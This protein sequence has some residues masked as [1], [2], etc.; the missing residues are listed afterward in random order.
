[1]MEQEAQGWAYTDKL[2]CV[3]CVDDQALEDAIGAEESAD[4]TCS[5]CEQS[6]AA[7]LDVLMGV[8]VNGL[9]NEYNG[10]D[11]EFVPYETR[12]GGYQFFAGPGRDSWD[13]VGEFEDILTGE[14]L[15]D[16]V[17]NSI[18][19]TM[20][21]ERDYVWR[22]RD[23]VLRDAWSTFSETVKY[24]T[25]YVIW[26]VDEVDEQ[27]MLGHGELP[28]GRILHEVG[29]LLTQLELVRLIPS[30]S[31]IWRAQ[32]H[33]GDTL[34]PSPTAGRL[35]TGKREHAKQPNRMSPSG[36]PMFYGAIDPDT[37]VAEVAVHAPLDR[38]HVTV[39]QFTV[40]DDLTVVDFTALPPPVPSIF[41]PALGHLRRELT[42]LH[43]FVKTMST[44]V[45]PCDEAIDYVPTQV[46]TE[47]F[48]RV[49]KPAGFPSPVGIVYPSAARP[50]GTSLVLD[51]DNDHCVDGPDAMS[52]D[53]T[54]VLDPA[55]IVTSP[56]S[57]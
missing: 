6:P 12:E 22:R 15:V 42:F 38:N 36:I 50:G 14:G 43:E 23:A 51:I 32:T 25:R 18:R 10:A 33:E 19:E 53:P 52:E 55:T 40:S 21:V 30:G 39:G 17:R 41:D 26:L 57:R 35:G 29:Q 11:D 28:P 20:W 16:E 45:A 7:S 1:M 5:F 8:F 56:I 3:S 34:L 2:V 31:A 46:L 4:Q 54:L 24:R 13:L 49:F 47:F 48:L 37:A 27:E 9:L 44:P